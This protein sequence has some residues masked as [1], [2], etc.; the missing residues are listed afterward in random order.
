VV[1]TCLMALLGL[2]MA[3][4]ASPKESSE[5]RR[6]RNIEKAATALEGKSDADSLAAAA[7]LRQRDPAKTRELLARATLTAPDRPD[8]AWLH[9]QACGRVGGVRFDSG[10][11]T[12]AD[13]RSRQWGG[14]AARAGYGR[15]G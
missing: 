14:V 8:L 4:C 3:A 13:A 10:G 6:E 12:T 2:Q 11:R 7:L 5:S 1:S 9:V 15:Q